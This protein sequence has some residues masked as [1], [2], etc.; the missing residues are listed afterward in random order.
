MTCPAS[1]PQPQSAPT[2]ALSTRDRPIESGARAARWSG[3][4]KVWRQPAKKPV[5]ALDRSSLRMSGLEPV[6]VAVWKEAS[7]GEMKS[8]WIVKIRA[9]SRIIDPVITA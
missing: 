4:D 7:A 3:P 6:L 9:E 8:G 5:H 2:S 1:C